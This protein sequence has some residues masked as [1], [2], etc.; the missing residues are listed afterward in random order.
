[1]KRIVLIFFLLS[2]CV[3]NQTEKFNKLSNINFSDDLTLDEFK[4]RLEKYS[5]NSPYPDIDS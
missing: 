3:P 5:T 2:G 4:L 1:M